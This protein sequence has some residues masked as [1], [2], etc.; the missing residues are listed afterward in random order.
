M[1]NQRAG[2]H[3]VTL[4]EVAELKKFHETRF[5]QLGKLGLDD[6]WEC[7]PRGTCIHCGVRMR[8][9]IDSDGIASYSIGANEKALDTCIGRD[10]IERK[11][12]TCE[13]D[14]PSGTLVF[15]NAFRDPINYNVPRASEFTKYSLNTIVGR[16]NTMLYYAN[17][18]I[19]YGQM[20]NMSIGVYSNSGV[21]DSVLIGKPHYSGKRESLEGHSYRGNICLDVWRWMCMDKDKLA[22]SGEELNSDRDVVEVSVVPG[23]YLIEHYFDACTDFNDD[24]EYDIEVYSRLTLIK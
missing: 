8:G 5:V 11:V 23:K 20:G 3:R 22:D 15:V 18:G 2:R 21:S 16:Y 10:I 14:V 12:M 24:D 9:R 17:K 4:Y 13:I 19:G 6:A 1:I 7:A